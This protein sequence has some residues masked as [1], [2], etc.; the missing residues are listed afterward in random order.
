MVA[1]LTQSSGI[2]VL[3][4]R[5]LLSSQQ[6][7]DQFPGSSRGRGTR[8][9]GW[10]DDLIKEKGHSSMKSLALFEGIAGWAAAGSEYVDL[11]D[12]Y[13]KEVWEKK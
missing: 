10:F 3:S 12:G 2:V 13:E 4:P 11:I 8:A 1:R 6:N 9:A 7:T 5:L